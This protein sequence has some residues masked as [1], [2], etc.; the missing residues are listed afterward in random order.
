MEPQSA[1][2]DEQPWIKEAIELFGEELVKIKD[3]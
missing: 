2:P 1:E 3:D